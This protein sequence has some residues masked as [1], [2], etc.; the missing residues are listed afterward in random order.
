MRYALE[1]AFATAYAYGGAA[2]LTRSIAR[3]DFVRPVDVGSLLAL[4]SY[5]VHVVGKTLC[6]DVSAAVW[7]PGTR[8][9]NLSN[10]FNFVFEIPEP[11]RAERRYGPRPRSTLQ[12]DGASIRPLQKSAEA[13]SPSWVD[14][15][16]PRP[17]K[18][19][20][21]GIRSEAAMQLDAIER[22]A[23]SSRTNPAAA[24][25]SSSRRRFSTFVSGLVSGRD[26]VSM[27]GV[28]P[29]SRCGAASGRGRARRLSSAESFHDLAD[30][31][32]ERIL[33]AAEDADFGEDSECDLADGV[34]T[35]K[36]PEG[37]SGRAEISYSGRRRLH[38][39]C[40]RPRRGVAAILPP[41][42]IPAAAAATR[43]QRNI[44]AGTWVINKQAPNQQIW[45]S[46]P[47]SG[48][49][50]Y[51]CVD[52]AWTHTRNGSTLAELLRDELQVEV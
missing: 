25:A 37:P 28:V 46:S 10:T 21:P 45:L 52:G 19:V 6:V 22:L 2:P 47:K 33:D 38:T 43:L 5:V 11:P 50:R 40:A 44:P 18:T 23:A 20:L 14:A 49:C 8:E 34:L 30:E 13:R 42:N 35:L 36:L 16:R 1:L 4:K 32:L 39:E 41:R 17:L 48:P 29:G 15:R 51:E 31:A 3:V 12:E 24:P 26:V 7:K 27:R 9:S